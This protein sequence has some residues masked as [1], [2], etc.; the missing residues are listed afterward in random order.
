MA[1]G[2]KILEQNIEGKLVLN[3]NELKVIS[4]IS[5]GDA[6]FVKVI[7][8]VVEG[9]SGGG[10]GFSIDAGDE[11]RNFPLVE[12]LGAMFQGGAE[13]KLVLLKKGVGSDPDD[14][15]YQTIMEATS[16]GIEFKVPV[17][18]P[19]LGGGATGGGRFF[20]S[21][22]N[23]HL[24]FQAQADPASRGNLVVYDTKGSADESK[25]VAIGYHKLL[26]LPR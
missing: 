4:T 26:A 7:A 17:S 19:N 10:G 21:H 13:M 25:W 6:A 20:S 14:A 11:N 24:C 16:A 9:E 5:E 3:G 2:N 1:T 18:A 22:E 23:T 12:F 8:P 15:D